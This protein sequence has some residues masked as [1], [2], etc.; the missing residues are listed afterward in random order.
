MNDG[1][2]RLGD[3][4]LRRL[5]AEAAERAARASGPEAALHA[6]ATLF[7]AALGDREAH[8]RPDALAPGQE[9]FFVAGAFLVTPD[10]QH[11]MLVGNIGFPP[12]QKR[13]L[14]PIDGGNPGQV[15]ERRRPLLLS[16]TTVRA[17]FRQYLKTA[18]MGSAVYA[19][20]LW[21]GEPLGL[22]IAA[23]QARWTFGEPDLAALAALAPVATL[24]WIAHGGPD[25]LA[26]EYAA[27]AP[28]SH[29]GEQDL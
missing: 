25:W 16:D 23:A 12:E 21:H 4:H 15:I 5:L 1:S 24:S 26:H 14:I 9:Q 8:H 13:L 11:Q 27:Q 17:D 19:P 2:E 18:R 10:R 28:V 22:L 7:F 29:L 6:I 3:G 20:L